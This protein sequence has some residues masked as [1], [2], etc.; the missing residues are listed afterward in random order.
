MTNQLEDKLDRFLPSQDLKWCRV[1][2]YPERGM[3]K[4]ITGNSNVLQLKQEM[5]PWLGAAPRYS[6]RP[7]SVR[8][9]IHSVLPK[10]NKQTAEPYR[11]PSSSGYSTPQR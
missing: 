10:A 2:G 6:T 7:A 5:K 9:W 11:H 3:N 1:S 8:P 4:H